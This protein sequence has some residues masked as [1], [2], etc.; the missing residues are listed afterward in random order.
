[1]E[2]EEEDKKEKEVWSKADS[3]KLFKEETEG[4][5]GQ[6]PQSAPVGSDKDRQRTPVE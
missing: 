6:A 4:V 1:M 2:E 3:K 5:L